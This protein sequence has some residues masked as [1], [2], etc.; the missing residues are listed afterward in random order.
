MPGNCGACGQICNNENDEVK[1]TSGC[2]KTFHLKCAQPKTR[3]ARKDWICESCKPDK[4]VASNASNASETI[5]SVTKEFFVKT[6]EA[7]KAEMV[8]ELKQ[9]GAENT[10]LRAS[11]QFLSDAVDKSNNLMENM[12]KEIK[13]AQE[14]NVLLR[15][16]NAELRGTLNRLEVRVRNMEQ[17]SRKQNIEINGL[18]ETENEDLSLLL[19]DVAKSIGVEMKTERVVA[20]HRVPSFN[21]KRTPPVIVRFST[22]EERD[23]W[24]TRFKEVR[25]L[26]ANQVNASLDKSAKV[27]INEHLSP[28]NKLLLSKAKEVARNKGYKYVWSRDGKIFIRKEA[29]ERCRKIE[30]YSDIDKL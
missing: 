11:V 13:K 20:A 26:T 4:S 30:L 18:P 10:E 15:K 19:S 9:Y 27:F 6:L 5:T 17:H 3:G 23:A 7:F 12:M 16:E 1:C 25:P 21:K 14:D 22:Y 24:I 8:S 28:E 29:G 2:K